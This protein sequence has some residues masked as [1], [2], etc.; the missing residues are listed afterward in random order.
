MY[1]KKNYNNIINNKVSTW[2]ENFKILGFLLI[3]RLCEKIIVMFVIKNYE[4]F[5]FKAH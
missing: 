5:Q 1:K 4:I 2:W 3:D